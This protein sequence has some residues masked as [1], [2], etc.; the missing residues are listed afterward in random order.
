MQNKQTKEKAQL[1][2]DLE[3]TRVLIAQG[4]TKGAF[5]IRKKS[6]DF[7][8]YNYCLLGACHKAIAGR[9]QKS[10]LIKIKY[11]LLTTLAT[12]YNYYYISIMQFNDNAKTKKKDV[13]KVIDT[14]LEAVKGYR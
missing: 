2:K 8:G 4:W 9:N 12:K 10:R 7:N 6:G 1:I 3:K 14:A 13:L 5:S 11:A